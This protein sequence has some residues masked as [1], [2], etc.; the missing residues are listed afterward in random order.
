MAAEHHLR[1]IGFSK[2]RQARSFCNGE[3]A[4]NHAFIATVSITYAGEQAPCPVGG[5]PFMPTLLCSLTQEGSLMTEE[6]EA[7]TIG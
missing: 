2:N 5:T 3:S 1:L 6:M 4:A 7:A